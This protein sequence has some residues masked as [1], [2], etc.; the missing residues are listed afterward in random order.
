MFDYVKNETPTLAKDEGLLKALF[1]NLGVKQ[2]G[3]DGCLEQYCVLGSSALFQTT[4]LS[5]GSL[6]PGLQFH[7]QSP[8][9][10]LFMRECR[11]RLFVDS[12]A[13][14]LNK[15]EGRQPQDDKRGAH[16]RSS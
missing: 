12:G 6:A 4:A 10:L 16:S 3:L 15:S 1:R 7:Q 13:A 2:S 11:G 5:S 9:E 8:L 14:L